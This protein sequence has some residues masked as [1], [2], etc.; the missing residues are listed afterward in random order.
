[1]KKS[2]IKLLT[3]TACLALVGTA[4][5]AWVYAGT[6]TA[7]ANIGVKVASYASAG[8]ITVTGNDKVYVYLDN[9]SV[10]FKRDSDTDTLSATHNVPSAFSSETKTVTKTFSVTLSKALATYVT[11]DSSYSGNIVKNSTDGTVSLST[12]FTWTDGADV[13]ES[14]PSLAWASDMKPS[15]STDYQNMI[16]YF[17]ANTIDVD[18]WDD[19]MNK[20]WDV[21]TELN[22][23]CYALITFK[24][25]VPNA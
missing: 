1:M 20:E 9:D 11:F 6:A 23:E 13:F 5:A 15:T 24:A 14:L 16:N 19:V 3:A 12:T 21:T 17:K 18:N 8:D 2:K 22:S 7:S 10:K 25:E 4:S